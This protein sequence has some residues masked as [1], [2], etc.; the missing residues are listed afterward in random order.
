MTALQYRYFL[1]TDLYNNL[2]VLDG[3]SGKVG[4]MLVSI[5]FSDRLSDWLND[6]FVLLGPAPEC[7]K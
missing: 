1:F 2:A 5:C 4:M 3:Y 6:L 7:C